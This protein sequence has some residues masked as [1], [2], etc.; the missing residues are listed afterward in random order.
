MKTVTLSER[1]RTLLTLARLLDHLE[2]QSAL[3]ADQYRSVVQHLTLELADIPAG[4]ELDVL[5]QAFP[6]T[7]ELY[8]NLQYAHAGLCRSDLDRSLQAE[9]QARELLRR[10]GR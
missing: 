3:P 2:R 4:E 7:A 1:Y 9:L 5:L 6:A 10:V 8:E